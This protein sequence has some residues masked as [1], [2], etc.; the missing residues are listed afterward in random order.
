MPHDL[1]I[2][3]RIYEFEEFLFCMTEALNNPYDR[4]LTKFKKS[5]AVVNAFST[6]G[7]DFFFYGGYQVQENGDMHNSISR[8]R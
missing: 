2:L 5:V 7:R 8:C 6:M 3:L 4:N 1:K